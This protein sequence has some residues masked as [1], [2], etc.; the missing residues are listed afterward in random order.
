M[1]LVVA[2]PSGPD[3]AGAIIAI[4]HVTLWSGEREGPFDGH[5][6]NPVVTRARGAPGLTRA[7]VHPARAA[8]REITHRTDV[9]ANRPWWLAQ[10]IT[11]PL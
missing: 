9:V 6:N 4:D 2:S 3:D 1:S 7:P 10:A 5:L 11:A 8:N